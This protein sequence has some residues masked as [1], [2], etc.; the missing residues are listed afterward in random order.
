VI[1]PPS[2]PILSSATL[3]DGWRP[4]RIFDISITLYGFFRIFPDFNTGLKS[5]SAR[6]LTYFD[7]FTARSGL[8]TAK[9]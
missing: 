9:I 6:R 7:D 4:S 5:E 8:K 1:Y 3:S 2:A